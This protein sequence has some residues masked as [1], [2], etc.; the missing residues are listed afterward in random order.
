MIHSFLI[1][2]WFV[3]HHVSSEWYRMVN[4]AWFIKSWCMT[5]SILMSFPFVLC[6]GPMSWS[7]VKA[8]SDLGLS[9]AM[10]I[11]GHGKNLKMDGLFHGK[12]YR[13]KWMM[14]GGSP[15]LGKHHILCKSSYRAL[16]IHQHMIYQRLVLRAIDHILGS[17]K[18]YQINK[19]NDGTGNCFSGSCDVGHGKTKIAFQALE[20]FRQTKHLSDSIITVGKL[21][22]QFLVVTCCN[23]PIEPLTTWAAPV[24]SLFMHHSLHPSKTIEFT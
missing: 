19:Y 11:V 1:R 6:H 24:V 9:M 5:P 3:S 14:T 20:W 13:S 4:S 7:H 23:N 21:E 17:Q 8:T 22:Y 12:S 15:I 18:W 16:L 10:A 2:F